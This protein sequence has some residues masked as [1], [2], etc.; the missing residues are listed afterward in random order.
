M[1]FYYQ[2]YYSLDDVKDSTIVVSKKTFREMKKNC[3]RKRSHY[4]TDKIGRETEV[5]KIN[6]KYIELETNREVVCVND[7][8]NN[9][10]ELKIE[11]T[12]NSIVGQ[13]MKESMKNNDSID[14][15]MNEV[16]SMLQDVQKQHQL[17]QNI[18]VH[19]VSE[20]N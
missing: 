14:K 12:T 16:D 18:Q 2:K 19:V 20:T 13:K 3:R 7:F 4:L 10:N 1:K 6:K 15:M 17:L 9:E 11:N 5:K 8:F